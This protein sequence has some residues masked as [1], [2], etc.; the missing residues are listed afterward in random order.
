[1]SSGQQKLFNS[2]H[3]PKFFVVNMACDS[4]IERNGKI[5]DRKWKLIYDLRPYNIIIKSPKVEGISSKFND[6]RNGRYISD[7]KIN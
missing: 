2:I 3:C 1:M 7:E 5:E 4:I 6:F